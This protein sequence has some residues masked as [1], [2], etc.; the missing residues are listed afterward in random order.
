MTHFE[1]YRP[2]VVRLKYQKNPIQNQLDG[3]FFLFIRIVFDGIH[4]SI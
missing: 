2:S 4:Y 1:T 3:I